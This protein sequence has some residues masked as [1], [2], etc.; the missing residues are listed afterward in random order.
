MAIKTTHKAKVKR[1]N[2]SIPLVFMASRK[3]T[4][5]EVAER[6]GRENRRAKRTSTVAWGS[7]LR[8]GNAEKGVTS[9]DWLPPSGPGPRLTDPD[10]LQ[11]R[12]LRPSAV[13]VRLTARAFAWRGGARP[14]KYFVPRPPQGK[15]G[16]TPFGSDPCSAGCPERFVVTR[17]AC[18]ARAQNETDWGVT[19]SF[20]CK[21][22][23]QFVVQ[24]VD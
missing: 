13:Y 6:A 10:M 22:H 11:P 1:S 7:V 3:A 8:S 18:S 4:I 20:L 19:T 15:Y 16:H 9:S 21:D 5:R 17:S 12:M 23:E 2:E 14:P 24:I